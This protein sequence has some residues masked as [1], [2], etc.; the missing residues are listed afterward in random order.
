MPER[1]STFDRET[2]ELFV[3]LENMP[4]STPMSPEFLA[5]ERS[6]AKRLNLIDEWWRGS[7]VLDRSLG[8]C[9]PPGH[10]AH[11]EWYRVRAVRY[12]LLEAVSPTNKGRG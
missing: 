8:P 10:F 11:N 4:R 1:P 9:H 6:L 12:A 7:S 5:G 2:L 3:Q